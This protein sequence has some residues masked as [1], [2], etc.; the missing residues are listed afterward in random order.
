MYLSPGS[1]S[2]DEQVDGVDGHHQNGREGHEPT[3][4]LPP[5]RVRL[6]LVLDRLVLD[7]AEQKH[8]LWETESQ[9]FSNFTQDRGTQR[10]GD[11]IQ[12]C[13]STVKLP[14]IF[15]YSR[16]VLPVCRF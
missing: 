10:C 2:D 3:N 1:R 6:T 14:E 4:H 5:P 13:I 11:R 15:R 12:S 16:F 9:F 8:A 7:D